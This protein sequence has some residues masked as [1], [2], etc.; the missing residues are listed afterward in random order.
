MTALLV[1]STT[2]AESWLNEN[3]SVT[4]VC[5]RRQLV[6]DGEQSL[7]ILSQ[8]EH[9]R[10]CIPSFLLFLANVNCFAVQLTVH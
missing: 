5:R 3:D 7:E 8:I 4:V 9:L 2:S 6:S 1:A 10:L